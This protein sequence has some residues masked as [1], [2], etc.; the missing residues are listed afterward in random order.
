MAWPLSRLTT[1]LANSVPAIKAL[2]LNELQDKLSDLYAALRSIK[3][4]VVDG[5]GGNAVTGRAGTVK[6][7]ATDSGTEGGGAA[8]LTPTVA[9]GEFGRGLVPIGW[10]YV[11]G[12]DGTL[13]RGINVRDTT[14]G[15]V[16]SYLVEFNVAPSD[17]VNCCALVTCDTTYRLARA[18]CSLSGGGRVQV[19]VLIVNPQAVAA[20][21]SGFYLLLFGE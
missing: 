21:D 16:G 11:K 13:L 12:S 5:N 4:L 9:L 7:S 19:E 18:Q 15:G 8:P 10:A 17:S 14:R 2:D 20:A 1:Y 3:A 6:V